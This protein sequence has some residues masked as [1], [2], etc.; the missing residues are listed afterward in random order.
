VKELI[1]SRAD[2]NLQDEGGNTALHVASRWGH[3]EIVEEL[4]TAGSKLYLKNKYG[5]TALMYACNFN[6]LHIVGPL[7]KKTQK[8]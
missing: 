4:I 6:Y 3:L 2:L 7:W 8:C 5:W 1:A